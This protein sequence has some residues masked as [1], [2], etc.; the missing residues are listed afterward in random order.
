MTVIYILLICIAAFKVIALIDADSEV[1]LTMPYKLLVLIGSIVSGIW[2][3][4]MHVNMWIYGILFAYL[5]VSACTDLQSMEVYD[6]MAYIA[7]FAG[8]ILLALTPLVWSQGK[9]IE[10]GVFLLLQK[11]LFAHMIGGADCIAFGVCAIFIVA[12]GGGMWEFLLHMMSAVVFCGSYKFV[13]WIRTREWKEP[14]AFVPYI[15]A[16]VLL[17]L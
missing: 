2:I 8:I 6:F 9:L 14:V 3:H 12:N 13:K 10:L 17:F 7:A 16:T 11:L 5:T 1:K 4:W 15:A